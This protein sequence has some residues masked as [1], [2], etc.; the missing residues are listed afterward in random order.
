MK[1]LFQTLEKKLHPNRRLKFVVIVGSDKMTAKR[2]NSI[3]TMFNQ[4]Y[5]GITH[6][7][8]IGTW[9]ESASDSQKWYNNTAVSESAFYFEIVTDN[10]SESANMR[11]IKRVMALHCAKI[12]NWV[13]IEK[14]KVTGLHFS[15]DSYLDENSQVRL[16]D[17]DVQA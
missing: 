8:K 6:C 12:S 13:H 2:H 11:I 4:F 15:I 14:S 3:V 7:E 16:N 5:G 9:N 10:L 17:S 1:N